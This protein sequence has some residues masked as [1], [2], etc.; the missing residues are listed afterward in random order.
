M[1]HMQFIYL[2][3]KKIQEERILRKALHYSNKLK[4]VY[5]EKVKKIGDSLNMINLAWET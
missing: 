4:S 1:C 5:D 3:R 2:A